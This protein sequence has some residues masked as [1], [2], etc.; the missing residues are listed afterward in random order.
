MQVNYSQCRF[1]VDVLFFCFP[2]IYQY[3]SQEKIHQDWLKV[4]VQIL[5]L[6]KITFDINFIGILYK[7]LA[8]SMFLMFYFFPKYSRCE[9]PVLIKLGLSELEV[10]PNS[11][12]LSIPL[13]N[14]D[15]DIFEHTG[16]FVEKIKNQH[17]CDFHDSN[18]NL[19]EDRLALVE[20][21]PFAFHKTTR[22]RLSSM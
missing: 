22:Y 2:C 5:F 21:R 14:R 11:E 8:F 9:I 3:Y 6:L 7:N 10:I 4:Q 18:L 15:T 1:V 19:N 17:L 16:E 12:I 13:V 20:G